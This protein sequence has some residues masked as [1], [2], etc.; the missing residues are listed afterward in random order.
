[1][2]LPFGTGENCQRLIPSLINVF[3]GR[4]QPFAVNAPA[5]R[6]FL[7]AADVAEGFITLLQR[8]EGGACNISSGQPV[9]LGDVVLK[10][11]R[12]LDADPQVILDLAT[13]HPGE[14]LLLAG[15]NLKL[16]TLGWQPKLSLEQGLERTVRELQS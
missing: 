13:E 2:F 8:G 7:H 14:P 15:E 6:D 12:L 10:L 3:R 1:V 16:K 11:A 5:Y 4:R 9:Q